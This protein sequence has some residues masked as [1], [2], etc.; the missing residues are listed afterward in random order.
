MFQPSNAFGLE[1]ENA[2]ASFSFSQAKLL[3][4][5]DLLFNNSGNAQP[6]LSPQ[7]HPPATCAAAMSAQTCELSFPDLLKRGISCC[8]AGLSCT[9]P[10]HGKAL[11]SWFP[12]RF[13][14]VYGSFPDRNIRYCTAQTFFPKP[15]LHL[16]LLEVFTGQRQGCE[17]PGDQQG[18]FLCDI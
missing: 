17:I 2:E 15:T 10:H 6:N 12:W 11:L 18:G 5:G 4:K 16:Q 8:T 7:Q 1:K 14:G 13:G 3:R 9:C